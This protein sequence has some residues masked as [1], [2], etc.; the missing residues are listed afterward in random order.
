MVYWR[1]IRMK[2]LCAIV[3]AALL[4]AAGFSQEAISG[5]VVSVTQSKYGFDMTVKKLKGVLK[6]KDVP[7]FA[8][9]DHRKNAKEVG[10]VMPP[11][12]VIVFGNPK[13]GTQLMLE[14][15][16]IALDLPLKIAVVENKDKTVSLIFTNTDSLAQKYG[17]KESAI[18][19]KMQTLLEN[20]IA[21]VNE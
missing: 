17:I 14:D 21:S 6:A 12:T 11:A 16:L 7:I 8:E 20:I 2:K 1:Y 3:A 10:L 18:L 19:P 5:D 4:S 9:F 15:P 13:V